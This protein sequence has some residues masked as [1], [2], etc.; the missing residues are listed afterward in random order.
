M[1]VKTWLYPL[2][3]IISTL[4][5]GIAMI[6][7]LYNYVYEAGL[8]EQLIASFGVFTNFM[9]VDAFAT[10][11]GITG[12]FA[13]S[14]LILGF[15]GLLISVVLTIL[16]MTGFEIKNYA[17]CNRIASGVALVGTIGFVV[18]A[19]TFICINHYDMSATYPGAFEAFTGTF[20]LWM[21]MGGLILGTIASYLGAIDIAH[22]E[23]KALKAEAKTAAPVA[24]AE[25]PKAE[26]KKAEIKK[27]AAKKPAK[28]SQAKTVAKTE[29][30]KAEPAAK[31]VVKTEEKPAAKPAVVKK[32]QTKKA[33]KKAEPAK[34]QA[35]KVA[36]KTE[37][38][39]AAKKAE[40]KAEVKKS[41]PKTQAKVET[42]PEPAKAQ[43]KTEV[44]NQKKPA[45]VKN[46]QTKK[47]VA[48]KV[49]VKAEAKPAVVKKAESKKV[50]AKKVA[51]KKA[52]PAKKVAKPQPKKV[53]A[54]PAAKKTATKT[55][56]KKSNK[57]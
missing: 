12:I 18:S 30:K 13:S 4:A 43:P 38:K 31:P 7:P 53:E 23:K 52:E 21:A 28:K 41:Q 27:A 16:K 42:K 24:I 36:V 55:T 32:A 20:A 5:V 35:T 14:Y 50:A 48:K 11:V 29:T 10:Y 46:A 15:V 51:A 22:E 47:P 9:G 1:K 25:A 34:A 56:T 17:L 33:A 19:V 39:P 45:A 54:K 8:I 40:V 26:I 3:L 49:E 44:K 37:A 57:K 6:F 2:V